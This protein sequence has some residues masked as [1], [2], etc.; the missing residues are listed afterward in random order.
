MA[1]CQNCQDINVQ[2]IAGPAGS[3]RIDDVL[4]SIGKIKHGIVV[5]TRKPTLT[6]SDQKQEK[7]ASALS[8]DESQ[9]DKTR[10]GSRLSHSSLPPLAASA[11]PNQKESKTRASA[12]RE[13]QKHSIQP[14]SKAANNNTPVPRHSRKV[15]QQKRRLQKESTRKY[16]I[17]GGFRWADYPNSTHHSSVNGGKLLHITTSYCHPISF[18]WI[19]PPP[20][21]PFHYSRQ[22]KY[23]CHRCIPRLAL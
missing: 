10:T 3:S 23:R 19:P 18:N 1:A 7:E 11:A 21:S 16:N 22:L 9:Q 8:G 4:A 14:Y 15:I 6:R 20:L 5:T 13:V 2:C 17:K 12:K